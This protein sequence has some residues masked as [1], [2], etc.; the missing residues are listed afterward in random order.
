MISTTFLY[1]FF[2]ALPIFIVLDVLWVGVLM[3]NFYQSKLAHIFG[4]LKWVPGAL[5]YVFFVFGITYFVL[6]PAVMTGTI[7]LSQVALSGAL[8]GFVAYVTY[9]LVN[10]ATVRNWPIAVTIVDIFWGSVLTLATSVGAI[11][12][13][14]YFLMS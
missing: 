14:Q 9:D 6:Y 2:L 10:Q 11:M 7:V 13:Y 5:F 1:L 12:L 3:R 4:S 8:L